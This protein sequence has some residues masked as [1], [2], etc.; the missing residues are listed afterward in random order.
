MSEAFKSL[1]NKKL[2]IWIDDLLGYCRNFEDRFNSLEET[3]KIA[4]KYNIKFNV[5][6]CDLFAKEVK[7]CGRGFSTEGVEHDPARIETLINIPQSK[8]CKGPATVPNGRSVDEQII[9]RI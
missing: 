4:A 3:L 8:T 5:I 9:T 2:I 1:I 7:F 6:K